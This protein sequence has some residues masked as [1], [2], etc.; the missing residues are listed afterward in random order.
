M[1]GLLGVVM[2]VVVACIIWW[3]WD[4]HAH[5]ANATNTISS[6]SAGGDPAAAAAAS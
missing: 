3:P 4:G 6:Y 1:V 2:A 5:A